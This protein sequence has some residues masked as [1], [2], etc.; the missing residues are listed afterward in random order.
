MQSLEFEIERFLSRNIEWEDGARASEGGCEKNRAISKSGRGKERRRE[1]ARE[2]EREREEAVN[3]TE[4]K[5]TKAKQEN[6]TVRSRAVKHANKIE[7]KQYRSIPRK[8]DGM[9]KRGRK[10]NKQVSEQKR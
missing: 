9:R 6:K 1:E 2:E 4:D 10:H 3:A 8:S 5:R 7:G